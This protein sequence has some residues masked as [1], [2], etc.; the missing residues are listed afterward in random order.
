MDNDLAALLKELLETLK[1][2]N[3]AQAE[4]EAKTIEELHVLNATL[5]HWE[6]RSRHATDF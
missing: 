3:A 4:F 5:R 6:E 1:E 2:R